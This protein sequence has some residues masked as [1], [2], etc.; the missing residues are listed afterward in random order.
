MEK[1]TM[2]EYIL[3]LNLSMSG[4]KEMQWVNNDVW[5][6]PR[7]C[8]FPFIVQG[9]Y[10]S[11]QLVVPDSRI[12][13]RNDSFEVSIRLDSDASF[14]EDSING[15]TA[16]VL[17]PN[18]ALKLPCSECVLKS[19]LPRDTIAFIYS[20]S[21]PEIL[22]SQGLLPEENI[23]HFTLNAE[24]ERLV[25]NLR[26]LIF[27]LY[28]PGVPDQLDW[29]CFK[30]YRE[31]LFAKEQTQ[32]KGDS[33]ALIR[34]ISTWFQLH[35]NEEI[36]M[37]DVAKTFGLSHAKFFR[38]WKNVFSLTPTQY[39]IDLKLHAAAL[40]LAQTSLAISEIVKEVHFSGL[41]AFHEKFLEKYGVTPGN[42]RKRADLWPEK[43]FNFPS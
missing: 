10:Y 38:E 23:W 14:C 43:V 35:Y 36:N 37:D 33:Q 3:I 26:K 34:N 1:D 16:N 17:F 24:I 6:L 9:L 13:R 5:N 7:T 32:T 27:R 18:V 12:N 28:T 2:S 15:I 31:L 40:R 8:N 25:S 4:D 29:V 20:A 19:P 39:V 30:L 11:R 41:N 42:F 22:K 21:V